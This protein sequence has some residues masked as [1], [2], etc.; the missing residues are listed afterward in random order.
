M[1]VYSSLPVI[2]MDVVALEKNVMAVEKLNKYIKLQKGLSR[3]ED[4]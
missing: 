2:H 1:N 3:S 4:Y